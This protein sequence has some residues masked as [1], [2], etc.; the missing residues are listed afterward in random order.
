MLPVGLSA[1]VLNASLIGMKGV[2]AVESTAGSAR[3][4]NSRM[5]GRPLVGFADCARLVPLAQDRVKAP[6]AQSDDGL[7]SPAARVRYRR[8]APPPPSRRLAGGPQ[9]RPRR[10]PRSI[11][12][13]IGT[14]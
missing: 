12:G 6:S 1:L 3:T 9:V 7:F 11:R 5:P 10:N 8:P 2:Q 13:T 4:K 14:S